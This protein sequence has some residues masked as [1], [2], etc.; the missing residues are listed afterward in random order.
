[1]LPLPT[2]LHSERAGR[3]HSHAPA[4]QQT[5]RSHGAELLSSSPLGLWTQHITEEELQ[6]GSG[7]QN[8]FLC[9]ISP[10]LQ[11]CQILLFFLIVP[12][13]TCL[14]SPKSH[15]Q[16]SILPAAPLILFKCLPKLCS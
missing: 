7:A 10:A 4:E 6:G 1:M 8:F 14:A 13:T 5:T 3:P 2:L 11:L 9:P 12:D 15:G 16:L